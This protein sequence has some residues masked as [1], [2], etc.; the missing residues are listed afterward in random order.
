M[1]IMYGRAPWNPCDFWVILWWFLLVSVTRGSFL[2]WFITVGAKKKVCRSKF[3]K[4]SFPWRLGGGPPKNWATVLRPPR[5]FR[6]F[7]PIPGGSP[8]KWPRRADFVHDSFANWNPSIFCDCGDFWTGFGIFGFYLI[9]GG[10]FG[11]FSLFL[12]YLG[13]L[14]LYLITVGAKEKYVAQSCR[15]RRFPDP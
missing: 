1:K 7:F 5:K 14:L 11:T 4:T 13:P 8:R 10:I 12:S 6:V 2:E 9:L 3:P 15:K